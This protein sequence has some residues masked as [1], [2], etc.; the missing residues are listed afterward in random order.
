MVSGAPDA[1]SRAR[2]AAIMTNSKRLGTWRTQSSTVTRAIVL[3]LHYHERPAQRDRRRW[4][5]WT[6][7]PFRHPDG[8]A[9]GQPPDLL[10]GRPARHTPLGRA[11]SGA[12]GAQVE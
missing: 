5:I 2:C 3:F 7:P 1:T 10:P 12:S 11:S 4:T 8:A 9:S 6:A